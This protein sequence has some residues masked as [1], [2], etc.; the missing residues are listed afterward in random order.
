MRMIDLSQ[1]IHAEMPVFPGAI[2][3]EFQQVSRV[4]TSG[5]RVA[6]VTMDYHAGTHIDAPAHMLPFGKTLDEFPVDYFTGRAAIADF[7]NWPF[8]TISLEAI[9]N[10]EPL[11]E[12]TDY[13]LLKTG[14]SNDWGSDRYFTPYPVLSP[15]AAEWLTN[16]PLKGVGLD[17]ISI[18]SITSTDFT[19]HRILLAKE[20]LV[21]ENLN[22]LNTID[23]D[24]FDFFC[25]PLRIKD[26][27][28]SPVRASAL[29]R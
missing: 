4:E 20:I 9:K 3:P 6:K 24:H 25:L 17:A 12:Q 2:H 8:K 11:L 5:Y 15:E 14:W 22:N 1:L 27:D 10:F 29:L 7:I 13:L 18:D 26:A 21:I 19:I 16:F 28:G 23:Q